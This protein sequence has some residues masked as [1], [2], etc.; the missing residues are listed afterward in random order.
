MEIV[1]YKI[2]FF[3]ITYATRILRFFFSNWNQKKKIS[4]NQTSLIIYQAAQYYHYYHHHNHIPKKNNILNTDTNKKEWKYHRY[5]QQ[6]KKNCYNITTFNNVH[7]GRLTSN[8]KRPKK[9]EG[10]KNGGWKIKINEIQ[11]Y[12]VISRIL[13]KY[14][15]NSQP[16]VS[17]I[18]QNTRNVTVW[19]NIRSL[20]STIRK[21]MLTVS[22]DIF[23]IHAHRTKRN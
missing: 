13:E 11:V 2:H 7:N 21:Y 20:K 14:I 17:Y 9:K 18:I 8:M 16:E 10:E 12:R 19:Q 1:Y 15:K 22:S 6:R 5:K 4:H 3:S 23:N